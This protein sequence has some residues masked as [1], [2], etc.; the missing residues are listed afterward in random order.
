[1]AIHLVSPITL[2]PKTQE[3]IIG[4]VDSTILI[5]ICSAVNIRFVC[6]F[7]HCLPAYAKVSCISITAFIPP[8]FHGS[9]PV[10]V[11]I[12]ALPFSREVDSADVLVNQYR[13]FLGFCV[14]FFSEMLFSFA[15]VEEFELL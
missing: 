1:M 8:A 15:G 6:I 3:A 9:S 12:N 13:C 5:A 14:L 7:K 10:G 11:S 2:M 4:V